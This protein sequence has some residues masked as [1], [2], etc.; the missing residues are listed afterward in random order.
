MNAFT[1]RHEMHKLRHQPVSQHL[2][3]KGPFGK[4]ISLPAAAHQ[5]PVCRFHAHRIHP[6]DS[7][8]IYCA[9]QRI[10]MLNESPPTKLKSKNSRDDKKQRPKSTNFSFYNNLRFSSHDKIRPQAPTPHHSNIWSSSRPP[11]PDAHH[12]TEIHIPGQ[13]HPYSSTRHTK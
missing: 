9:D 3:E 4:V 13:P 5:P 11:P 2:A 12:F 10:Y 6:S 7:P 1:D 8:S